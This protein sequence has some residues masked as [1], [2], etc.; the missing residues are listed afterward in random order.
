M[1]EERITL[2]TPTLGLSPYVLLEAETDDD[3]EFTINAKAG[4]GIGTR[5]EMILFLLLAIDTLTGV[6]TDLYVKQI[7]ATRTAAG[8]PPLEQ[9][10]TGSDEN[11]PEQP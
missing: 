1:P 10:A 8:L 11:A 7:D 4:G 2:V 5:D 6:P 9:S 3:G